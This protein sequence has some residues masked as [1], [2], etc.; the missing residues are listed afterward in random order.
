M[1]KV[2]LLCLLVSSIFLHAQEQGENIILDNSIKN[3]TEIRT[4]SVEMGLSWINSK[5]YTSE[6]DFKWQN[7]LELGVEY[8]G[9]KVGGFGYG[10]SFYH[11]MTSIY[12]DCK[13]SLNFI[14][15][16]LV[17][18]HLFNKK[19]LGKIS[20]GLGVGTAHGKDNSY[21]NYALSS[22]KMQFGLGTRLAVG[23][24]YLAS[25][26]IGLGLNL[27]DMT[28]FLG[29]KGDSHFSNSDEINGISRIGGTLVL[30]YF[31]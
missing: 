20:L 24:V 6:G 27:H 7:G 17:Y 13:V 31:F 11:N 28:I 22:E 10:I 29:K 1:R 26:H 23:M 9:I 25:D 4:L 3:N 21:N 12:Y 8:T 30:H 18:A 2:V 16:S 5:V 15:A 19:W 14:G